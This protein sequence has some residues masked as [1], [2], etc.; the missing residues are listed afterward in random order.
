MTVSI[1]NCERNFSKLKFIK[2]YQ[3]STMNQERL[4]NLPILSTERSFNEDFNTFIE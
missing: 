1:D 3:R 4:N 2:T